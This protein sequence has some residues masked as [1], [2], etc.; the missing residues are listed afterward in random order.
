MSKVSSTTDMLHGM[1][2]LTTIKT[3]KAVNASITLPGGNWVTASYDGPY[4]TITSSIVPTTLNNLGTV[5]Y[6]S[7]TWSN[8]L[9]DAGYTR[10]TISNITFTS[11]IPT[12]T[13]L[14]TISVGALDKN[15]T[16]DYVSGTA[17]VKDVTAYVF[18]NGVYYNLYLYSPVTIY[19]PVASSYLF[20][21]IHYSSATSH[22]S[23]LITLS[24]NNFKTNFVINMYYMFGRCSSLTSLNL[25]SFNTSKVTDMSYMFQGCSMLTSLNV[26]S[27]NTSKVTTM[28][29][30]FGSC[31]SLTSLNLSSF[32]TSSVTD[33]SSMFSYCSGL[34]SLDL[35]SFK[36]SNVT[37]M[38]NMFSYCSSLKTI[39]WSSNFTTAKVKDMSYMFAGCSSLTS[40]NVAIGLISLYYFDLSS[41]T[42]VEG[43]LNGLTS[44]TKIMSPKKLG[45]V[46]IALP[47]RNWYYNSTKYTSITR[48]GTRYTKQ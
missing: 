30:M 34:T 1:N 24:F 12:G 8:K 47:E 19:A 28:R 15:G 11:T 35:D 4:T 6:L 16:S 38:S 22:F 27:F 31:K 40:T 7:T 25:S 20:N 44:A 23:S 26:S 9:T 39:E 36:T 32:N 2:A 3:P 42:N 43:M 13:P 46:S 17:Y 33:M 37:D 41:C 5:S 45:S 21:T 29:N 18:A 48:T 10:A 14:K